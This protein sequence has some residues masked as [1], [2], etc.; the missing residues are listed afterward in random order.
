MIQPIRSDERRPLY[1][2][3]TAADRSPYPP[4]M[5]AHIDE[6]CD[7]YEQRRS[8]GDPPDI[9]AF[10][11]QVPE[12]SRAELREFLLD[13]ETGFREQEAF[14]RQGAT[15]RFRF[16]NKLGEGAYGRVFLAF[17]NTFER[18]VTVKVP[19]TPARAAARRF[20][21]EAR[22]LTGLNHPGIPHVWDVVEQS[23]NEAWIISTYVEGT[24]LAERLKAG[25]ALS[26]DLALRI[27]R[28]LAEALAHAHG[29]G[30]VH[31]DVKPANVLLEADGRVLLLDFGLAAWAGTNRIGEI[32]G[33]DRYMAPEAR[34]GSTLADPRG[35]LYSLGVLVREMLAVVTEI[36]PELAVR[37]QSLCDRA[38][39]AAPADR[40]QSATEFAAAIAA[41]QPVAAPSL[42]PR[43]GK[44]LGGTVAGALVLSLIWAGS[45]GPLLR[46]PASGDTGNRP[47][48]PARLSAVP[49]PVPPLAARTAPAIREVVI[50]VVEPNGHVGFTPVKAGGRDWKATRWIPSGQPI[51]LAAGD[52]LV[53]AVAG[54]K[55]REVYR[56]VPDLTGQPLP[57]GYP[58]MRSKM[59]LDQVVLPAVSVARTE[60]PSLKPEKVQP[61]K[62]VPRPMDAWQLST[63]T[64]PSFE[65]YVDQVPVTFGEYLAVM[66]ELPVGWR[67]VQNLQLDLPLTKISFE[68]ATFFAEAS[69]TRLPELDEMLAMER[70]VTRKLQTIP[71]VPGF[72]TSTESDSRDVLGAPLMRLWARKQ[73]FPVSPLIGR[74]AQPDQVGLRCVRS[75]APRAPLPDNLEF[76]KANPIASAA[77]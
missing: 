26:F 71:A 74:K 24:T 56:R 18:L 57:F 49:P 65:L 75:A 68:D 47:F 40:F 70:S 77:R 54:Q 1:V 52:Y 13:V 9:E 58:H 22:K 63:P 6:L 21:D 39:A 4:G 30:I 76:S 44:F 45:G 55:F 16:V 10:L 46:V 35:D 17:D 11:L 27:A 12:S 60:L 8:Q 51:A 37:M 14:P 61:P 50:K 67:G 25:P 15:S 32:A 3:S 34:S 2:A 20:M 33:T 23:E 72:W 42:I 36:A 73:D 53:T 5:L 38:T 69:G 28:S 31:R 48:P 66:K 59:Q 64:F 7:Q 41:C 43:L 62:L 29:H 19:V